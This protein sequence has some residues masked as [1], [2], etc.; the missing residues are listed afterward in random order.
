MPGTIG[1]TD[2]TAAGALRNYSPKGGGVEFVYDPAT[3][4]FVAGRPLS[5]LFQ[6]SPHEQ[7][8]QSIGAAN[9]PVVGGTFRRG[10]NGEIFTTENSG[11]YGPNWTDPIRQQFQNWLSNRV[12]VP[13]DHQ[14]WGK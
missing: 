12:G 2:Q 4:T 6:G 3:N 5:G 9:R 13:V 14:P 7:L 10:A 8:A 11:H 1:I